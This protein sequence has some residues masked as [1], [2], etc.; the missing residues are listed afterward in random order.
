[1]LTEKRIE[2]ISVTND[3]MVIKSTMTGIYRNNVLIAKEPGDTRT[4]YPGQDASRESK[5]VQRIV[6]QAHVQTVVDRYNAQVAYDKAIK[7]R[8]D[9]PT[10]A[11]IDAEAT[12]KAT[13]DAAIIAY[14]LF[15]A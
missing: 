14:D 13:L 3:D 12:A 6:A 4:I 9:N 2:S 8:Q 15:E 7:K 5:K 11:N 1:M 10:Q